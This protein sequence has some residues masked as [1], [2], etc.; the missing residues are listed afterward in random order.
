[1]CIRDRQMNVSVF[2][3]TSIQRVFNH[4]SLLQ[5]FF[6][7]KKSYRQ[8]ICIRRK[9]YGKKCVSLNI[10]TLLYVTKDCQKDQRILHELSYFFLSKE[11]K[12][13]KVVGVTKFL[14]SDPK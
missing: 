14:F 3:A 7:P 8:L 5:F 2:L 1:M 10:N 4:Q 11:K 6:F 13:S 12:Y 9:C